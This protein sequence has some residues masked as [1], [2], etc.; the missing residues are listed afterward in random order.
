MEKLELKN[1][2]D[3][4]IV[5]VLEKPEGKI[6]GTCVVQH[7]WGGNRN[8]LTVQAIKNAF[9]E[10]GFQTFNFDTTNSFGESDGDFEKS[11][12]GLFYEDLEDV[13][14]WAQEQECFIGPLALTGHS[15]GGYS[16]LKYAEEYPKEVSYVVPIAPVVSGKLSFEKYEKNNPEELE[17]W[18]KECVRVRVGKEGNVR[19]E[20]YFQFEERLNHDLIPKAY[21][22]LMPVLIIVGSED[23]SCPLEHQ[24]ILFNA[25]PDGNKALEVI[26]GA[27]HSYNETSEQEK[28]KSLIKEW[29]LKYFK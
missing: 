22:L 4:K 29:L 6:K 13:V 18:K 17:K 23:D 2:K 1:R 16:I 20:H 28:C 19:K 9:L 3:Q 25:I 11:T 24:Q 7:G 27:P 14:K 8:K 10:S 12:L 15:K 21:K 5:G 26:E